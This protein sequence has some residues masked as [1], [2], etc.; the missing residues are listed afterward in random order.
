LPGYIA[1]DRMNSP[2]KSKGKPVDPYPHGPEQLL[3]DIL[4]AV[5]QFNGTPQDGQLG[6]LSPKGMLEA[7]IAATGWTAQVPDEATFDLVFSKEVR[8]DVR[9][10]SITIDNRAYRGPVLAELIGERQVPFLVPLRDPEGPIIFFRNNVIH[11]LCAETFA[12]NDRD[13]AKHKGTVIRLQKAEMNRRIATADSTVDVQHLLSAS[14]DMGPV[15]CNPPDAWTFGTID[16]AG[17]LG[18]PITKEEAEAAEEVRNRKELEEYLA[19]K[20]EVGRGASGGNRNSPSC[21]T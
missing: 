15:A 17:V 4:L 5:A 14:A 7:K 16:K 8:R 2:T 11:R 6:G 3:S 1:G 19:A 12:L 21:A 20:R 13:G 10:G 9:K 18:G